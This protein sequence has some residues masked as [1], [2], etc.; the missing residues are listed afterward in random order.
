MKPP[1]QTLPPLYAEAAELLYRALNAMPCVCEWRWV[2]PVREERKKVCRRCRAL[3][4]W[5]ALR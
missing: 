3:A 5:D 2:S 1:I 4:G